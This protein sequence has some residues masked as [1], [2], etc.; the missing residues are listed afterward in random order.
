L[1][2]GRFLAESRGSLPQLQVWAYCLHLETF[3]CMFFFLGAKQVSGCIQDRVD[4]DALMDAFYAGSIPISTVCFT[5]N[6]FAGLCEVICLG[7][8]FA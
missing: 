3:F 1:E 7:Y 8:Y 5:L 6:Q 4:G 2:Q